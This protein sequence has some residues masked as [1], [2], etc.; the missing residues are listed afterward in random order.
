MVVLVS[1]DVLSGPSVFCF[2]AISMSSFIAA[3]VFVLLF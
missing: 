1:F 3:L 2:H